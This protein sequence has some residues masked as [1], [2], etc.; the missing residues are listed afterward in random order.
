MPYGSLQQNSGQFLWQ[1]GNHPE[2]THCHTK[3]SRTSF[4]HGSICS[5]SSG[6][7][8]VLP[9]LAFPWCP[10]CSAF[11][12]FR[13]HSRIQIFHG[14]IFPLQTRLEKHVVSLGGYKSSG[15]RGFKSNSLLTELFC[16][17]MKTIY[18]YDFQMNPLTR[19]NLIVRGKI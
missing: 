19:N 14:A 6:A 1:N 16:V 7:A 2:K 5:R 4:P 8:P 15:N 12:F 3:F 9:M 10:P 11:V 13:L 17:Q 18:F